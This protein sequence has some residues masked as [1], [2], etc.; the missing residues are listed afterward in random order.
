MAGS[1]ARAGGLSALRNSCSDPPIRAPRSAT[2]STPTDL[3]NRTKPRRNHGLRIA[4]LTSSKNG[5]AARRLERKTDC[6]MASAD[7]FEAVEGWAEN[8]R[9][10]VLLWQRVGSELSDQFQLQATRRG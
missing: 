2:N 8:C 4:C 10:S 6:L 3:Q 1:E 9:S 5:T 7:S